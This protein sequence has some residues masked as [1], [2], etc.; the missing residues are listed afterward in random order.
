VHEA[1]IYAGDA[2]EPG[3]GMT[4]PAI[5]ESE[6]TTIVVHPGD[7]MTVDDYGNVVVTVQGSAP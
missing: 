1:E 3:M 4:G 5:V 2:L 7:A 6:G